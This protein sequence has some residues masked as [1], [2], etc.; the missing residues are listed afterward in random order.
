MLEE[1]GRSGSAIVE[2]SDLV[3]TAVDYME[4]GTLDTVAVMVSISGPAPSTHCQAL[5]LES[6]DPMGGYS[7]A[8]AG[9]P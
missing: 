6:A 9:V 8:S 4:A 7:E 2:D 3:D 5:A 1:S